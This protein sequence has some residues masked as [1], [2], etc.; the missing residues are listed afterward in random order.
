[1]EEEDILTE[2]GLWRRVEDKREVAFAMRGKPRHC[3]E[4]WMASGFA[5]EFALKA[6][7]MRVR[8]LNAWPDR[9]ENPDLYVHNLRRLVAHA[10]LVLSELPLEMQMPFRVV[11]DWERNHDYNA[12]YMAPEV[13]ND[14]VE[15]AFGDGGV[16]A[17]LRR[18]L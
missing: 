5:V 9:S 14:I 18:Q 13:A 16:I 10:G 1:M 12:R 6:Y 8:R 15:A 4:A 17:W 11:L 3:R 7:I 2:D